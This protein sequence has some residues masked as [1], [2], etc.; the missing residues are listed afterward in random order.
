[1]SL[2]NKFKTSGLQFVMLGLTLR[3]GQFDFLAALDV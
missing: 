1:M 3:N 2:V